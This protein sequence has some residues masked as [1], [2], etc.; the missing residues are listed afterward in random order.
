MKKTKYIIKG[1]VKH[2]FPDKDMAYFVKVAD[3]DVIWDNQKYQVRHCS[4]TID[5]AT[6]YGSYQE[7]LDVI[8]EFE[9]HGFD[10]YPV[11]PICGQDYEEHPAISRKDNKTKICPNCGVGEAFLDFCDNYKKNKATN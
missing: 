5:G 2:V 7:A 11:C 9:L 4:A 3:E 1:S 10:A 6:F 8:R